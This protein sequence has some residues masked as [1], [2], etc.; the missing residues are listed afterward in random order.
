MRLGL[1]SDTHD[2][3]P[4]TRALTKLFMSA[5]VEVILHAGDHCS[6]FSLK[7]F[8]SEG[9][10]V[11][12]VFGHNDGDHQGMRAQAA[13]GVGIELFESPH[14]LEIG[15]ARILLVHDIGDV[16]ELSLNSHDIVIHGHTH[17]QEMKTRGDTLIVNPGEGCGWIYSA[18]AAALLETDSRHVEFLKLPAAEWPR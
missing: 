11:I 15:G 8:L 1:I 7:P 18:P 4:A 13:T 16:A 2:R 6:P 3:V 5:G 17:L 9:L 14:S 12:G 10:P